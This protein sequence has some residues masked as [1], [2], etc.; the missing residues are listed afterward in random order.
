MIIFIEASA[1]SAGQHIQ[2]PR[3]KAAHQGM[4]TYIDGN[5]QQNAENTSKK[6]GYGS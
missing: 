3:G 1:S 2:C 5:N 6:V 4:N